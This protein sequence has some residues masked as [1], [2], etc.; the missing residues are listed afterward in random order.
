MNF[1]LIDNLFQV[2][3][4]SCAALSALWAAFR[5]KDRL[6]LILA[7]AYACF[8]MGTLYWVLHIATTGDVPRAFYVAEISWVA[9]YF[10]YLSFQLA[11]LE[12]A[13]GALRFSLV[14]A[15]CVGALCAIA[16][17]LHFM[18]ILSLPFAVATGGIVYLALSAPK[19]SGA[20]VCLL[21][22]V[23]LQLGVY[24]SSYF[25]VD[26]TRF[27]LYFAFDLALTCSFAAV[28]PLTL[29]EVRTK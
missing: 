17:Y 3:V 15:L 2:V 7:F 23:L 4:L 25:I 14:P 22:C 10:F 27:N 26:F 5:R 21:L 19:R 28:L 8:A 6:C 24:L 29:R 11:R 20:D 16:L 9:S 18:G 13:P 1:E 12:G